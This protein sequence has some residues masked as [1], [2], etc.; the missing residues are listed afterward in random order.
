MKFN[1]TFEEQDI[2]SLRAK[3][4]E[5]KA[6]KDELEADLNRSK[7][8]LRDKNGNLI[9]LKYFKDDDKRH[10]NLIDEILNK[11]D[12]GS[13][14]L[15]FAV[16]PKNEKLIKLDAEFTG[17]CL[18]LFNHKISGII[19]FPSIDSFIWSLTNSVYSVN[20]HVNKKKVDNNLFDV[21]SLNRVV[22]QIH[23][24]AKEYPKKALSLKNENGEWDMEIKFRRSLRRLSGDKFQEDNSSPYVIY[25]SI[26]GLN[27]W[28]RIISPK[29][30]EKYDSSLWKSTRSWQENKLIQKLL[31]KYTQ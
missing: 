2:E 6:K 12:S 27:K 10:E 25:P 22:E 18:W 5:K 28:G 26:S 7:K 4:Y 17:D 19:R 20:L 15:D 9:P 23:E 3:Y 14:L 21:K 13:I 29:E 8:I 24:F 31:L 11:F 30:E 1:K 16:N